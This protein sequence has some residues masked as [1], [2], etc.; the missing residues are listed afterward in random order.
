MNTKET[1]ISIVQDL[2]NSV[3]GLDPNKNIDLQLYIID[4]LQFISFI[5]SVEEK[6][7]I[8]FPDE[9]LLIENVK[10][11]DDFAGVID[12]CLEEKNKSNE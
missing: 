8:E 2:G 10:F 1:I 7:D 9:F 11:L 12:Y 3:D 4:S 5:I 6:F